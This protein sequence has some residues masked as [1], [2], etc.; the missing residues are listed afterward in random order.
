VRKEFVE[1]GL[2]AALGRRQPR[3]LYPRKLDGD[4]EARLVAF[5]I[6]E[7]R[8]RCKGIADPSAHG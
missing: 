3:R 5:I 7:S 6:E 8:R 2:E 1:E 4:G